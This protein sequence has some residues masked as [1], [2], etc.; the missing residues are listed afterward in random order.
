M[1]PYLENASYSWTEDSVRYMNTPSMTARSIYFYVQ[2]AGYFKTFPPYFTERENLD[3][4]LIVYTVSGNGVLRYEDNEYTLSPGQCFWLNCTEHHYY[5][6]RENGSWEFA[7]LHFNAANA[8]GY[9]QEYVRNGFRISDIADKKEFENNMKEILAVSRQTF[10]GSEAAVS[11]LISHLLT[12]L[13]L[14]AEDKPS[15]SS[16]LPKPVKAAMKYI[17]QHFQEDISLKQIAEAASFS[18]CYLSREF[19]KYTGMTI[20]EYLISRRIAYAKMQL[21]YTDQ[22]VSD[23]A[24][25]SGMC[26]VSHFIGIFRTR[27]GMT[28]LS[29][30]RVWKVTFL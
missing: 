20:Q 27:V 16:V 30:R 6:V 17:D 12:V 14:S 21:K 11:D 5:A 1:R 4:F 26:S 2:E 15:D 7:W 28:P 19:H 3:S 22:S 25:S 23:I 18:R 29:F 8:L 9:Y 13:L 24:F 10:A